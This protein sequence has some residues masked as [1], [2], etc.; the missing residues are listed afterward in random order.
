MALPSSY[1]K[2]FTISKPRKNLEYPGDMQSGRAED[3]KDLITNKDTYL[4][5]G[6]THEDLD[7]G[8]KTFVN[9]N[10]ELVI[11]G[12]R[13]PVI[14]MGIQRWNE[15]SKTW[16]FNDKY[17]NI[18][19][20]FITIVRKPDTQ[21]GTN[22][23]YYNIPVGKTFQ[24]ASYPT[25]DGNKK[26]FDIYKIPQPI[27]VDV[28][29]DVR[30]IS[31]RQRELN[32]FNRIVLQNFQSRQAYTVVNGHYMPLI[33]SS[34]EDESQIDDIE[35]KRFY[36]QNYNILLQGIILNPDDFEVV[37]SINRVL[38]ISEVTKSREE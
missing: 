29:Y 30:L 10:L 13:I 25:F 35:S 14:M 12:N 15:I 2:Q 37:P 36:V 24:Y 6:V 20:P 7:M 21:Y 23:A 4:P 31:Y 32:K 22:P 17:Q 18:K 11:D 19:I 5:K 33:L 28:E 27:P 26:G 1:K 16:V 38:T 8:M 34:I 3:L 9:Q